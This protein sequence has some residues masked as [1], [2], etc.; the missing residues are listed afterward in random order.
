MFAL[1][2]Y[3]LTLDKE[4]RE[5]CRERRVFWLAIT[6]FVL[7][8]AV[9]LSGWQS[10]H[11]V[12]QQKQQ[13]ADSERSRWLNQG[14]KGPHSAA[15]YGVYV[16]KPASPLAVVEPGLTSYLGHTLLLEAHKQNE[17]QFRPIQDALPMQRFG[18]LTP[19]FV[20]QILLPLLIILFGF[21]S[22]A[23]ERDNG[24]LQ[25]LLVAGASPSTLYWSKAGALMSMGLLFLAPVIIY[26]LIIAPV[27]C[28]NTT[29][30]DWARAC[31]LALCYVAYLL[32]WVLL[33]LWVSA[34]ANTSRIALLGLLIIWGTLCLLIPKIAIEWSTQTVPMDSA[35]LFQSRMESEIYTQ[36]R[37][38]AIEQY[39]QETLHK[40]KVKDVSELPFDWSGAQLQFGEEYG[41]TVFDRLYG[42][43]NE[44]IRL[45][46]SHYE[47][48][49]LLSPVVNLQLITTA[50]AATDIR[51]HQWFSEAAERHRRTMQR[52]LNGDVKQHAKSADGDY[53]AG[54]A[55]WK[56]IPDFHYSWPRF[57]D[58]LSF[59]SKSLL[60]LGLWL[61]LGLI[62]G[63]CA[64]NRLGREGS[65]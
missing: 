6:L 26:V 35:R 4:W 50:A 61:A 23:G 43:R 40:Y 49:G 8:L 10:H 7:M 64:V 48:A 16:M 44:A 20:V 53:K 37:L 63:Q 22:L 62:A 30:F 51:H 31:I 52:L 45:Q 38:L 46:T 12:S 41:D 56:Q 17:A 47:W 39:K 2:L 60:L 5:A 25:Q 32:N 11:I 42:Q 34:L 14:N 36:E 18:E 9:I 59:Y 13:V 57:L 3:K 58:V 19:G 15:H 1:T 21:Q 28:D 29:P 33:T 55:L 54:A 27:V 24:T 65:S